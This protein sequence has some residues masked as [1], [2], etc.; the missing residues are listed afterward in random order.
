MNTPNKKCLSKPFYKDPQLLEAL[1]NNYKQISQKKLAKIWNV[2]PIVIKQALIF[3]NIKDLP[4]GSFYKKDIDENYFEKIDSKDKAYFLGLMY[5]DGNI[6][7]TKPKR[8]KSRGRMQIFLNEEDKY[9]LEKFKTVLKFTEGKIYK[10]NKGNRLL[11]HNN[12]LVSDLQNKGIIERKSLILKFPTEDQVPKSLLSHFI[13]G[14][15]DGDG[16]FFVDKRS[17]NRA[18]I[19]FTGCDLFINHLKHYLESLGFKVG[20]FQIRHKEKD[21]SAGSI[22]LYISNKVFNKNLFNY[23]YEDC[24]DFFLKRKFEKINKFLNKY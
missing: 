3:L 11:I 13:R 23:L 5:A 16:S 19:S 20:K 12:K 4:K 6:Y 7:F 18:N 14:Y 9:I 10:D 24:E 17:S 15:F 8:G 1:R 2:N 21:I 22:N